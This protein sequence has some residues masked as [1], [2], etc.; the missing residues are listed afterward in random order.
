MGVDPANYDFEGTRAITVYDGAEVDSTNTLPDVEHK[1]T[2]KDSPNVSKEDPEKN[3]MKGGIEVQA[4]LAK[5]ELETGDVDNKILQSVFL[6]ATW[7]SI[8]LT[9]CV[10]IIGIFILNFQGNFRCSDERLSTTPDVL[11]SLC[12]Q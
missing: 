12:F 5:G 8:I 4:S 6:R 10:A 9:A 2:L 1:P 11:F 7:Y 3:T